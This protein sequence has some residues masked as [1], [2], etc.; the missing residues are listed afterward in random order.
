L[1]VAFDE[2]AASGG[3]APGPCNVED[4][5]MMRRTFGLWLCAMLAICSAALAQKTVFAPP[6]V[7]DLGVGNVRLE[8]YGWE[9]ADRKSTPSPGLFAG[10]GSM[11]DQLINGRFQ[12]A[13]AGRWPGGSK[14]VFG[15]IGGPY[16]NENRFEVTRFE[17]TGNNIDLVLKRFETG[18]KGD[19]Y[20]SWKIVY[21]SALLPAD[22]PDGKYSVQCAVVDEKNQ[23][24]GM[25]KGT[26]QCDVVCPNPQEEEAKAS[27]E[28]LTKAS[29]EELVRMYVDAGR[30]M[31]SSPLAP[32]EVAVP[33]LPPWELNDVQYLKLVDLTDEMVRRGPAVVPF[34]MA[35]LERQVPMSAQSRGQ[36]PFGFGRS[37]MEMLVKI[38]D[39]RPASLLV[40]VVDGLDGK[41]TAPVRKSAL[42]A[43][44][45]LTM[46]TFRRQTLTDERTRWAVEDPQATP[47]DARDPVFGARGPN[48]HATAFRAWIGR[49]GRNPKQWL[50]LACKRAREAIG[51]RDLRAIYAAVDF[52]QNEDAAKSRDDNP[53][54]TMRAVGELLAQAKQIGF[55]AGNYDYQ[56]E[57]RLLP[58]TVADWSDK[59]AYYGT[60][61]RPWAGTL[62]RFDREIAL[63]SGKRIAEMTRVGGEEVVAYLVPRVA[64]LEQ[65]LADAN[66]DVRAN[67]DN[68]SEE[69][70][71][72][73]VLATQAA[74]WA[75]ARWTGR[76]FDDPQQVA[77]WWDENAGKSQGTWLRESLETTAARADRG[78]AEAQYLLRVLLP[79]L[80]RLGGDG[81][82]M[83]PLEARGA[84]VANEPLQA[85]RVQWVR[86][87]QVYLGY[88]HAAG[89]FR[90]DPH[91]F[92]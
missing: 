44:E 75:L 50:S 43:V 15:F 30:A 26:P 65:R 87:K 28:K 80:P 23:P 63:P 81:A 69:R 35:A 18:G 11:H 25:T 66:L 74:R 46:I 36:Y 7:Q 56:I 61:A 90:M 67:A 47:A 86:E 83:P 92:P 76:V 64:E 24:D 68:L 8:M 84:E 45:R 88:D 14:E 39:P 58:L 79:E 31:G 57:G 40:D 38:G 17:R 10:N 54:A 71:R 12:M 59:L 13:L 20:R 37:I 3:I 77:K 60:R 5:A 4:A 27:R 62:I 78:D 72:Q 2:A 89:C 1:S 33:D 6:V 29:E 91:A 55:R 85:F 32:R 22:L 34:L 51:G 42:D 41:A 21:L 9:D 49:E 53:A 73:T 19:G 82:F 70:Q 52:L 48:G 16:P